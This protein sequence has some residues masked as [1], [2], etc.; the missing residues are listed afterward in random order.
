MKAA[1]LDVGGAL[2]VTDETTT[3]ELD[4]V[5]ELEGAADEDVGATTLEDDLIVE[6]TRVDDEALLVIELDEGWTDELCD[7]I[8]L[9]LEDT[10]DELGFAEDVADDV[11][12]AEEEDGRLGTAEEVDAQFTS[13]NWY[14]DPATWLT[15]T[16]TAAV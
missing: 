11:D 7:T 12:R 2:E 8:T 14:G 16:D 1:E 3:E 15:F 6:V 5:A 9:E 10:A 4:G 13:K